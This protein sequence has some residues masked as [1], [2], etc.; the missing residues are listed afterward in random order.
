MI[1]I[2]R[3]D[4]CICG[5]GKKYKN[6]CL[7][8]EIRTANQNFVVMSTL[9][10]AAAWIQLNDPESTALQARIFHGNF[11][12][13]LQKVYGIAEESAHALTLYCYE[14][15]IADGYMMVNGRAEKIGKCLFEE[16]GPV[17]E[18]EGREYLE[19]L[20]GVPLSLYQIL[21]VNPDDVLL[22]DML[23]G[24]DSPIRAITPIVF[25]F[26]PKEII[27]IRLLHRDGKAYVARGLYPFTEEDGLKLCAEISKA[28]KANVLN[29]EKQSLFEI[30]DL[31]IVHN[32][33]ITF[34]LQMLPQVRDARTKENIVHT[35]DVFTVSDWKALIR[36]LGECADIKA[37]GDQR[38]DWV[39][40]HEDGD[41]L[42]ARLG[43][44]EDELGVYSISLGAGDLARKMIEKL[45]G[46]LITFSER[47]TETIRERMLRRLTTPDESDLASSAFPT[48]IKK[49]AREILLRDEY[50]QWLHQPVAELDNQSP[51][52]AVK[53]KDW[54]ERV[55]ALVRDIEEREKRQAEELGYT[56]PD[57]SFLRQSLGLDAA[58][59]L[60]DS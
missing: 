38:W 35:V 28:L 23:S 47:L 11:D 22:K 40:R 33:I 55:I 29:E 5:S 43:R 44:K 48:E 16:G 8:K 14:W 26:L 45:A 51:L 18:R 50:T 13:L 59:N 15:L 56:P 54:R 49:A 19:D 7:K 4:P 41:K 2:G 34:A 46:P 53:S 58:A 24:D 3:N 30:V 25:P 9:K 1:K 20:V 31:P 27:G 32:W 12:D 60:A 36:A 6:C 17:M 10:Q 21:E 37:Y 52:R 39:E 57:L 42:L